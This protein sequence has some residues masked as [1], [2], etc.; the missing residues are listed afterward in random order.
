MSL[1]SIVV[2]CYNEEESV[3]LF[4]KE[5]V[6]RTMD[7]RK[8]NQFEFVFVD[9]GSKDKTLLEIKRVC[10]TVRIDKI[11]YVSFSRNFGKEAA[12]Y[13]GLK[14]SNGNYVAVMDVDLQDP[15][16][17]ISNML[18]VLSSSDADCV[19]TRRSTRQGEPKMRSLF[20]NL[21]YKII[22]K[23]SDTEIINGARDFRLMKR[24][25]VDAVLS[26]SEKNRFSK[27]IFS[28]VGFK[29]EW[30][31]YENIERQAGKTKWN[32]GKL[33]T[34]ALDGFLG[35]SYVLLKLPV[36]FS[37]AFGIASLILFVFAILKQSLAVALCGLISMVFSLIFLSFL[38]IGLYVSNIDKEVKNRPIYVEREEGNNFD[39]FVE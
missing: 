16:E 24:K 19:A 25:M 36:F 33:F 18:Q 20:S 37:V 34:Y 2:P 22:N 30:I 5:F 11:K 14:A 13:A 15:P 21:F 4:Y 9:D 6:K 12:L 35:Y 1:I 7:L 28:W 17:L 23:V 8:N 39:K 3:V 32:F 27:G 29:T 26:L 31:S 38:S 10:D